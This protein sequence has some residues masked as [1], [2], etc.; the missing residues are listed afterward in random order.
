MT[1]PVHRDGVLKVAVLVH[2]RDEGSADEDHL[3]ATGFLPVWHLELLRFAPGASF[4]LLIK[5]PDFPPHGGSAGEGL[6]AITHR[7]RSLPDPV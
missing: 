1:R 7:R 2:P 3:I 6:P 4:L 5:A